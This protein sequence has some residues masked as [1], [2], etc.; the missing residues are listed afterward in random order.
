MKGFRVS[1]FLLAS[2]AWG[3]AVYKRQSNLLGAVGTL[4]IKPDRVVE[5]E[6]KLRN[7]AKHSIARFGPFTLPAVDVSC[8]SQH[9]LRLRRVQ[10][11]NLTLLTAVSIRFW[12]Q[13]LRWSRTLWQAN[14][15]ERLSSVQDDRWW[16]MLRLHRSLRE[17]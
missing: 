11:E 1:F 8:A 14:G 2:S 6:S 16:N 15:S 12:P 13:P 17:G 5:V 4:A 7:N 9:S 10:H 3:A